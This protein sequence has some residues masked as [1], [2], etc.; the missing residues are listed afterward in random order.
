MMPLLDCS[1]AKIGAFAE[2]MGAKTYGQLATPLTNY[3]IHAGIFAIDNGGFTRQDLPAFN[4]L[5]AKASPEK[6][7]CRFVAM[8]D[9]PG[10]AIRTL[11]L[12]DILHPHYSAWP[13]ALVI[14]NGQENQ[15]IPW[16]KISAIFIAGSGQWRLSDEAR[17][18]IAAAKWLEKWVHVGRVS[19]PDTW[20]YF[21]KLG[22]DSADSSAFVR[23]FP[24]RRAAMAE[25]VSTNQ[26]SPEEFLLR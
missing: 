20:D 15:T 13:L 16:E 5:L 12:F 19:H 21:A 8:P 4:R 2:E 10:S 14:Q 9:V 6:S 3:R 17:H 1:P 11:E 22:C 7:R 24:G 23:P 25:S 18:I 26:L